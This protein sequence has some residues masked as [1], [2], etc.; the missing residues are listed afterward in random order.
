MREDGVMKIF[1][2]FAST[3]AFS[4]PLHAAWWFSQMF[5]PAGRQVISDDRVEFKYEDI[6]CGA[7]ETK[8][9]RAPEGNI[10]EFRNLFCQTAKDT[11]VEV[12]VNCDYPHYSSEILHVS[13][14]ATSFSVQ[15][16]CG[17]MK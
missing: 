4:S 12:T 6:I 9:Y 10:Y 11:T 17:P 16:T 14:G 1:L 3:V 7:K 13:K 2:V 15:L 8:F 5:Y